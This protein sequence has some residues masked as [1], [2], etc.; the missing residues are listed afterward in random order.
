MDMRHLMEIVEGARQGIVN[1]IARP[2]T[3]R[4][5]DAVLRGAG[6]RCLGTGSFAAVYRKPGAS[7][8]LKVFAAADRAYAAFIALAKQHADNPHF[9]RF[10]GRIVQVTPGY[11]AIRMEPLTPYR[12]DETLI[13]FYLRHRDWTPQDPHSHMAMQLGDALEY[14][15]EHPRMREALDLIID[16]LLGGYETDMKQDNLMMRGSTVVV[17]DPVKDPLQ[18]GTVG[19]TL[20]PPDPAEAPAD[21]ARDA[22]RRAEAD[23][24]FAKLQDAGFLD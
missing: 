18:I 6:Y 8:V 16:N 11:H 17:T 10:F 14:L 4:D 2:L 5:A 9:P 13:A 22:R 21:P 1:E 19:E 15:E 3:R 20:P 7:Y 12:Y 24:L 23:D